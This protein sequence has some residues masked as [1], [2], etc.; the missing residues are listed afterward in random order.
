MNLLTTEGYYFDEV[1][2]MFEEAIYLSAFY[3]LCFVKDKLVN[4]LEE[5]SRE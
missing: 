5:K 4:I 3:G 1:D 2:C